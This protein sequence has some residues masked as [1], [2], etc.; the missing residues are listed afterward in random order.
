MRKNK[1]CSCLV[2]D[3]V[4]HLVD[5]MCFHKGVCLQIYVDIH[6]QG[7][8]LHAQLQLR[9]VGGALVQQRHHEAGGNLVVPAV[10]QL[11]YYL[12]V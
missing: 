1:Q 10:H 4:K 8:G 3:H 9:P 2:N 7:P 11:K 6:L 12:G 5:R